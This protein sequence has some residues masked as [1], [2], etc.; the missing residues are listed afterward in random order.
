MGKMQIRSILWHVALS[1]PHALKMSRILLQGPGL[2]GEVITDWKRFIIIIII[3][4]Q[5]KSA[6][7]TS[8]VLAYY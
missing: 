7:A 3:I 2:C 5:V 8:T 6:V 1:S 4:I